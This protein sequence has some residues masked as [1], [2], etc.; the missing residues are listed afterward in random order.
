[1]TSAKGKE[2]DGDSH[3]HHG[4]ESE[5]DNVQLP[6]LVLGCADVPLVVRRTPLPGSTAVSVSVPATVG[7]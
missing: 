1:M 6:E 2:R 7:S 4:D 5:N 3:L